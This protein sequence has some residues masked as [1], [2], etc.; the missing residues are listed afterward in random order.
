MFIIESDVSLEE[1]YCVVGNIKEVTTGFVGNNEGV[2]TAFVGNIEEGAA[3]C[4]GNIKEG[5]VGPS[6]AGKEDGGNGGV[7]PEI[8]KK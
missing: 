6:R 7:C 5:A 8:L 2:T 1:V 4:V 3:V